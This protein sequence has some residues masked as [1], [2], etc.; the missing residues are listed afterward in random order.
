LNERHPAR[1]TPSWYGDS[2]GH[3]EGDTLVIDTIG[4]RTQRPFAMLDIYGTPYSEALHIVE[5]YRLIDPEAATEAWKRNL[6]ENQPILSNDS[7]LSVDLNDKRRALQLQ[8]TVEDEG[9]FTMPWSAAMTYR[10]AVGNWPEFAC[11]ENIQWYS[12]KDAAVPRADK[13]DF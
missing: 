6:R 2:V 4:V 1:V 10:R 8:F 7:G 11:A 9:M 5:R 3:Y 13:P 12:G